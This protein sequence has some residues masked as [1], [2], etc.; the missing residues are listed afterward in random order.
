MDVDSK[1]L[2]IQV[3]GQPMGTYLTQPR[4][5]GP[6]PGLV[7]AIEGFG[8]TD[9][10]KA[11]ANRLAAEGYLVAVPDMYHRFGR[12]AT[13]SYDDYDAARNLMHQVSDDEALADLGAA[14]DYIAALP[15]RQG[16]S[17]GLIGFRVGGR[18]AYLTA[19][20]RPDVRAL[21]SFYGNLT[22][23]DMSGREAPLPMDLTLGLRAAVLLLAGAGGEPLSP[24][25]L[26]AVVARL[27][28]HGKAVDSIAYPGTHRGFFC[29]PDPSFDAAAAADAWTRT[30]EWLTNHLGRAA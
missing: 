1:T 22:S 6:W 13:A 27:R 21:I 11:V 23:S 15:A 25:D 7:V 24:D 2:D 26:S 29:D 9:H 3:G 30:L 5:P 16:G 4:G 20:Q 10:I 19:C 12:F 17:L 14:L 18:W 8:V 28:S